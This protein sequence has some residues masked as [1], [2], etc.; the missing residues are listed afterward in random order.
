MV[1]CAWLRQQGRVGYDHAREPRRA[2]SPASE[3]RPSAKRARP[4]EALGG[5][6]L[7]VEVHTI[8]AIPLPTSPRVVYRSARGRPPHASD[9]APS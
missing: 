1:V 2:R 6:G 8:G 5:H 7:D 3:R 4:A 9:A